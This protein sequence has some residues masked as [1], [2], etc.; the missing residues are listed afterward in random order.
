MGAIGVI[1]ATVGGNV[2]SGVGNDDFVEVKTTENLVE[3]TTYYVICNAILQANAEAD[4]MF[5]WR[6]YDETNSAV[7]E[8]ST[9]T[10][11]MA[12]TANQESY[13]F[14]GRFTAGATPGGLQFQQ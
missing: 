2:L 1:E 10:R 13:Q 6:M 14:V 12:R 11:E 8:D 7:L 3:G 4:L 5:S 9:T